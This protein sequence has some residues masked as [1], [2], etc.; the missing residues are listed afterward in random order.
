MQA[1][2]MRTSCL[3]KLFPL[4]AGPRQG[5]VGTG[6]VVPAWLSPSLQNA[7]PPGSVLSEWCLHPWDLGPALE[8]SHLGARLVCPWVWAQLDLGCA[9]WLP[10]PPASTAQLCLGERLSKHGSVCFLSSAVGQAA[11]VHVPGA[12]CLVCVGDL[13]SRF[14]PCSNTQE[15]FRDSGV[16]SKAGK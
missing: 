12:E 1:L 14:P 4:G 11:S 8:P 2:S 7:F 13:E 6:W 10:A 15:G 16:A 9:T 3:P 5:Q